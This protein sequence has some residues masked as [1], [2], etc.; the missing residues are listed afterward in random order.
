MLF[1]ASEVQRVTLPYTQDASTARCNNLITAA[2]TT[3]DKTLVLRKFYI[4]L[5]EING[6]VDDA[7]RKVEVYTRTLLID[8]DLTTTY[9]LLIRAE[10]ILVAGEGQFQILIGDDS[11][12]LDKNI[13]DIK[14]KGP[15]PK[16]EQMKDSLTCAYSLASTG[17]TNDREMAFHVLSEISN[18]NINDDD[19][20]EHSVIALASSYLFQLELHARN[21]R[22]APPYPMSHLRRFLRRYRN[23]LGRYDRSIARGVVPNENSLQAVIN[24]VQPQVITTNTNMFNRMKKLCPPVKVIYITASCLFER[25]R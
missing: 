20:A 5:S 23:F 14:D 18:S 9:S 11:H 2:S 8:S 3:N 19:H 1:S 24:R 16:L 25:A 6:Y 21:I 13:I 17:D 15:K 7:I 22:I 4:A 12:E 10:H